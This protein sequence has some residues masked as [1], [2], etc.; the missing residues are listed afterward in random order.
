M[1]GKRVVNLVIVG[2][3][4]FLL[5]GP[6]FVL[7][8]NDNQK[9]V[10]VGYYEN[11]IF[12][13]GAAKNAVK[14]GYAYEYYM[15]LS[16]YSG[17]KYEY[18]YG[19]FGDLYQMLA[20]GDIDLLAGLAYREDR[21]DYISYP[22]QSMG[23][24][25]YNL[26]KHTQ[27]KDV[28]ADQK[29]I[30]G[31]TIGVLDSAVADALDAYLISHEFNATIVRYDDM[32]NLFDAFDTNKVDLLA[33]EGAGTINRKDY[34]V[35]LTF[36]LSDYYVCVNKNK[37]ELLEELNQAQMSLFN[38]EPY[39]RSAL[40]SKYYA[41]SISTQAFS[42]IERQWIDEHDSVT[43]GYLE[44]Y[45][46]Y[47]DTGSAGE[48]TGV[49]KE[50]IPRILS[51]VDVDIKINYVGY[52]NYW[53]LINAINAEDIDLA[54]PVGGGIYYAEQD[55]IYQTNPLVSTST[56][57]IY[58][59]VIV[60]PDLSTFA[61]NSNNKMQYYYVKTNFPN[62]DIV[63]YDS[64]EECLNAVVKGDVDC[65]TLNGLRASEILKNAAY[66][67]LS[68]RQLSE[69][70]SRSIG[71]KIGNEGLL[72]LL[73]RGIHILGSDYTENAAYKYS[74]GLY[75]YTYEDWLR[76]NY[77]AV[78]A[79][80]IVVLV[81]AIL[82][83][84]LHIYQ[85]K[86][87][88]NGLN[89]A[90]KNQSSFIE[91]MANILDEPL[92]AESINEIVDM[93][94]LQKR[95]VKLVEDTFNIIE[96]TKKIESDMLPKAEEK[97]LTFTVTTKDIKNKSIIADKNRIAQL[98]EKILDNAIIYTS[99]R[100]HI[101]MEVTEKFSNN[102]GIVRFQFVIKDDGIGMHEDFQKIAFEPF[103]KEE[104]R[105]ERNAKFPGLGLAIADSLT[106]LMGGSIQLKSQQ[107]VGS[108]FT[109]VIDCKNNY[110]A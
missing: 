33:T 76:N 43:V 92:E 53:D 26:I 30:T 39:F 37:P 78:F 31:K 67:G 22:E 97:K 35:L 13:E 108:E 17:W 16:E 25:T 61:I 32:T 27:D 102:P 72:H 90:N 73:N 84:V 68:M 42:A 65:T 95:K 77:R 107:G 48:V 54:F 58:D 75:T 89:N 28:T 1:R 10:K 56:D 110:R 55:G 57:L 50:I 3:V 47:C 69:K 85:T 49:I 4:L 24:E 66:D 82:V 59:K 34:D 21:L 60:N 36:G 109:V 9:T 64:T 94:L 96:L 20:D 45:L 87:L 23:S 105:D 41:S 51:S 7:A 74:N 38:D 15:K 88:I 6:L 106:K 14:S 70:D 52:S 46:P 100:G 91:N 12:Q 63:Y 104:L 44:N 79:G 5:Q 11:E 62:A 8:A 83:Q 103:T 93:S 19:T 2:L 99:P 98:I 86:M 80:L 71:V 81:I 29:T 40:S 101:S 18:V